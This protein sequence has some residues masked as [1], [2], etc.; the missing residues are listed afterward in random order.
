[1]SWWR[2]ETRRIRAFQTEPSAARFVKRVAELFSVIRGGSA[3]RAISSA[4]PS[5][6]I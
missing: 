5:I 3:G 1:M 4:L 2:I 6:A